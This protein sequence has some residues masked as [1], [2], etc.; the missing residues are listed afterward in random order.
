MRP[1]W[2]LAGVSVARM[3]ILREPRGAPA[4]GSHGRTPSRGDS[5]GSVAGP[6][7]IV[8]F[9]GVAIPHTRRSPMRCPSVVPRCLDGPAMF[10]LEDDQ[11]GARQTPDLPGGDGNVA[12]HAEGD[13]EQRIRAFAHRAQR[14]VD[15]VVRLLLLRELAALGL[16]VRDRQRPLD[17]SQPRVTTVE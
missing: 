8:V 1:A 11:G 12:E 3:P 4:R 2:M 9:V 7:M 10:D 17:A 16:L 15:P 13:L 14:V 5:W 6:M